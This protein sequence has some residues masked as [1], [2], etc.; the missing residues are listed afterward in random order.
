MIVNV[1]LLAIYAIALYFEKKNLDVFGFTPVGKRLLQL[2]LG[3]LLTAGLYAT[4]DL[5]V[6]SQQDF[7]WQLNEQYAW[8]G[9]PKA[10]YFTFNSV[11]FEELIFRSYLL[12]K[13][14]Q[15]V[16]EKKAVLISSAAFGIYHWFTFGVLGNVPAMIWVFLYTGLWGLMFAYA[17]TRTGSILFGIGLHW[18]WNF[19][20]QI[21]FAKDGRGILRPLL[22]EGVKLNNGSSVQ[23]IFTI[24][25]AMVVIVYLM[26]ARPMSLD[27]RKQGTS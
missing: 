13:L 14:V 24:V 15:L 25:F 3:I 20:D 19:F 2:L 9:L 27:V 6:A 4:G 11:V 7:S 18:G 16:G 26:K 10:L 12:Y 21:V 8:N 1:A 17:Y 23:T 5:T 22:D